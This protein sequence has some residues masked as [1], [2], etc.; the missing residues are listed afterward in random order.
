VTRLKPDLFHAQHLMD[1]RLRSFLNAVR[2]E[3]LSF[4][5]PTDFWVVCP[6]VTLFK[7][8]DKKVCSD[9]EIQ[10]VAYHVSGRSRGRWQ[11]CCFLWAIPRCEAVWKGLCRECLG[12][13]GS[14]TCALRQF[15][16]SDLAVDILSSRNTYSFRVEA[17][18]I[19]VIPY[20]STLAIFLH[21]ALF[22]IVFLRR[23]L[24]GL[25]S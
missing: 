16:G 22:R 11:E 2:W 25:G 9:Q 10:L 3:S 14:N 8:K 12:K 21:V 15:S 18:R 1:F 24:F 13:N 6:V 5:T 4:F 23:T 7:P 17:N 19:K 20:G